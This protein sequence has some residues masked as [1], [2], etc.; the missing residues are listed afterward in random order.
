MGE[1]KIDLT[2][3]R[4]GAGVSNIEVFVC[5]GQV[6]V[7]APPWIRVECHVHSPLGSVE[8][9]GKRWSAPSADSP[10]V[11]IS[12]RLWVGAVVVKYVDPTAPTF[13]ERLRLS[14]SHRNP[15]E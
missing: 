12:G 15:A 9:Q 3:A 6:T 11:R 4:L 1:L 7:F 10:V 13:L 2:S 14:A 8:I 5:V